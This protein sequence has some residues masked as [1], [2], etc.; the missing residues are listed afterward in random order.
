M[1]TVIA[2]AIRLRHRVS[3]G[4]YVMVWTLDSC[5][6]QTITA[7]SA[8]SAHEVMVS[9]QFWS[10]ASSIGTVTA[11][12]TAAPPDSVIEYRPV[13]RP[14]RCAKSRLINAGS[15]TLPMPMAAPMSA[16]PT[17]NAAVFGT[18]RSRMA[19]ISKIK[20]PKMVRSMP[21]RAARR[22]AIGAVIPKNRTGSVV[23]RPA[24]A[25]LKPWSALMLVDQRCHGD[26]GRAQV[27]GDQH[28]ADRRDDGHQ[29]AR[30]PLRR[31][32]GG[33]H[34]AV[35]RASRGEC[36]VAFPTP[37]DARMRLR[38]PTRRHGRARAYGRREGAGAWAVDRR[39]HASTLISHVWPA[40]ALRSGRDG[41]SDLPAVSRRYGRSRR[42]RRGTV[43]GP[44][45]PPQP[46]MWV[47]PSR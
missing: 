36:A 18:H 11:T 35:P 16:D 34:R 25:P 13:I 40:G 45:A 21:N 44:S 32:F 46:S 4:V 27:R 14:E 12:A 9:R 20:D 8:S 2:H 26:H 19:A 6:I 7:R 17:N 29:R 28:D 30:G 43:R 39:G 41:V 22:G 33:R 23:R 24:I 5:G 15:R 42:L 10:R 1:N 31:G 3:A 38:R 37:T 47:V